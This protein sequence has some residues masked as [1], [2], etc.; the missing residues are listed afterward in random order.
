MLSYFLFISLIMTLQQQ[1]HKELKYTTRKIKMRHKEIKLMTHVD[2]NNQLHDISIAG[3]YIIDML[4]DE[5]ISKIED[6]MIK[7]ID[8]EQ[9]D[10]YEH[11]E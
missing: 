3:Y 6:E 8:L 11:L 4:N 1:I 7:I 9:T 5:T 2:N 10:Y